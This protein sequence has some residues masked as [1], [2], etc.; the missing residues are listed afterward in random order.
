MT[1]DTKHTLKVGSPASTGLGS[2]QSPMPLI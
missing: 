2:D 1:V